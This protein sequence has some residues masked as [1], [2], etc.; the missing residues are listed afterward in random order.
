MEPIFTFFKIFCWALFEKKIQ[1]GR[2]QNFQ[3]TTQRVTFYH[4]NM[5]YITLKN[6]PYIINCVYEAFWQN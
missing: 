3:K 4:Y 6:W 5:V 1:D 2:L